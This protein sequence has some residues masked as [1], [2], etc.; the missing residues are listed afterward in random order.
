MDHF[1]KAYIKKWEYLCN[2]LIKI[3]RPKNLSI[4]YVLQSLQY[5]INN[6]IKLMNKVAKMILQIYLNKYKLLID[7]SILFL[8]SIIY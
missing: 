2:G 5:L 3:F 6:I 1:I 7:G 8:F 4:K